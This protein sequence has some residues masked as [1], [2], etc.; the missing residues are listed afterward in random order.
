VSEHDGGDEDWRWRAAL[1]LGFSGGKGKG[2]SE[3]VSGLETGCAWRFEAERARG[4]RVA[5]RG[6]RRHAAATRRARS[7]A[8]P[9]S[10]ARER[11]E[12]GGGRT[13]PVRGGE[14]A[15]ARGGG[16]LPVAGRNR[17]GGLLG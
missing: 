2:A 15:R 10:R 11:E 3:A 12:E 9:A 1:P 4:P 14:R 17:G 16:P 13:G 7:A 8:A 6:R 5:T